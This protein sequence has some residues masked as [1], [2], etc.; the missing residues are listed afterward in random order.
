MSATPD[1]RGL[2]AWEDTAENVQ[3]GTVEADEEAFLVWEFVAGRRETVDINQVL[4]KEE[5]EFTF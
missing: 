3:F 4:G 5:L 2:L 1:P